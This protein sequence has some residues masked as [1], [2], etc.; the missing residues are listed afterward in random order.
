[1]GNHTS[2]QVVAQISM[3]LLDQ[4]V[5]YKALTGS[6]VVNDLVSLL[7]YHLF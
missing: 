6:L 2:I 3:E 1:M 5:N 4:V 7:L